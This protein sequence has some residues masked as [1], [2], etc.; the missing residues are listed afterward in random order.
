MAGD[1]IALDQTSSS[2]GSK[3][4]PGDEPL[5]APVMRDGRR[6]RSAPSLDDIRARAKR[7]LERLPAPLRRLAPEA[8]YPVEIGADLVELAA[9]VDRR[10]RGD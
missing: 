7:D 3:Q 6:L 9:V 4:S 1:R 8:R 10:L 2:T 5:L